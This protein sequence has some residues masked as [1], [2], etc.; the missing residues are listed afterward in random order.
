MAATTTRIV[1]ASGNPGK[2][3][4]LEALLDG[5]GV[6]LVPQASLGVRPAEET[7]ATFADNALQKARHASRCTGLPAIADDSG[8]VVAALDGRP[9]IYSARYAG[10]EASD[11]DNVRKLLE[12]LDGMSAREAYFHCAA[13]YVRDAD[14]A[15]PIIA[16]ASWH[17]SISEER[18]GSGGFGYDPV[19][20][21]PE[22]GLNS[23]ELSEEQKNARSHR[24][25]AVRVLARE[26]A[27]EL[28][29]GA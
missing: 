17:G 13:V 7:G 8:L 18:R 9:G 20:Y 23:A 21:D 24:G 29:T 10:A 22:L 28:A 25:K 27:A 19:F 4:E 5:L 11:E 16:E 15:A 1:V 12:E 26:L 3:R 6:T 2:L 14:D